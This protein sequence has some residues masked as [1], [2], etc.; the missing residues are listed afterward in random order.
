[1]NKKKDRE[2]LL[3]NIYY[4]ID[5]PIVISFT[6]KHGEGKTTLANELADK[7]KHSRV[8]SLA[9]PVKKIAYMFGYKEEDKRSNDKNRLLLEHI[10]DVGFAYDKDIWTNDMIDRIHHNLMYNQVTIFFIDDSQYE[11]ISNSL[12]NKYKYFKEYTFTRDKKEEI[13]KD[14]D[15]FIMNIIHD[16]FIIVKNLEGWIDE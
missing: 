9:E 14:I 15:N 8:L 3:N 10:T 7:Y 5:N 13:I 12:A 2:Y 16:D 11:E 1:M 6:G 4:L